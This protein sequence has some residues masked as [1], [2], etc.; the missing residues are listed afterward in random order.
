MKYQVGEKV[1]YNSEEW[2]FYGTITAVIDNSICPCYRINVERMEKRNCNF[3]ITQFEF[4]LEKYNDIDSPKEKSDWKKY[5]DVFLK[6]N[7][8]NQFVENTTDFLQPEAHHVSEHM[9]PEQYREPVFIHEHES[10]KKQIIPLEPSQQITG[11]TQEANS[12]IPV[13][14]RYGSWETNFELYCSGHKSKTINTWMYQNR[15]QY[16]SGTLKKNQLEKLIQINFPFNV[17]KKVAKKKEVTEKKTNEVTDIWHKQLRQWKYSDNR[18]SLQQWRQQNVKRYVEGKL[19]KD[20]IE[21]LKE[22][23]ILK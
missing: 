19:S 18:T 16:H 1:K 21:K 4:E 6:Q 22:A 9:P 13:K 15:K 12:D 2:R 23:G 8:S 17:A 3:T 7:N 14:K 5:E 11:M 10:V 20:K